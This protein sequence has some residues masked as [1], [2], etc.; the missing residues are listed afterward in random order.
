MTGECKN[1]RVEVEIDFGEKGIYKN[2]L[3]GKIQN[4]F[5]T[6]AGKK[7]GNNFMYKVNSKTG[8]YTVVILNFAMDEDY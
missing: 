7:P 8:A 2:Q 6:F 1:K 5:I 3:S 4:C